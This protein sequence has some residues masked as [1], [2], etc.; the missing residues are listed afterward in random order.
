MA[1]PVRTMARIT[2]RLARKGIRAIP[3]A[4][5]YRRRDKLSFFQY[6]LTKKYVTRKASLNAQWYNCTT[7]HETLTE[8]NL[9]CNN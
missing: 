8:T 1:T 9:T 5:N 4:I 2:E 7:P 6:P 3:N